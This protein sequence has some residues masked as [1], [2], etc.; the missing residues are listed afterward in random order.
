MKVFL[1]LELK[2]GTETTWNFFLLAGK[3]AIRK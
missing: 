3:S 1:Q 2:E